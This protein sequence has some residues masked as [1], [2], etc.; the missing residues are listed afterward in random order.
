MSKKYTISTHHNTVIMATFKSENNS[1]L[2]WI[3][4]WWRHKYILIIPHPA[5]K[6]TKHPV[7]GYIIVARWDWHLN[8]VTS[9]KYKIFSFVVKI[10]LLTLNLTSTI[11]PLVNCSNIFQMVDYWHSALQFWCRYDKWFAI[12][13]RIFLEIGW[14]ILRPMSIKEKLYL[15]YFNNSVNFQA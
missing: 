4:P 12:Q 8:D 2:F 15:M 10:G 6:V 11:I 14:N 3:F 13:E 5:N 7:L 9:L 1:Q